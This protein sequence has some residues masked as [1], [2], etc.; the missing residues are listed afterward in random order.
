[1]QAAAVMGQLRNALR[2]Y[3]A[4]GH[5]PAAV[6][7][8]T[9]RL[10]VELDPGVFA[11][12]AIVT[13]DLRT[14]TAEV[15]LAGHPPPV[16]AR[17]SRAPSTRWRH[18]SG[19]RSA[20]CAG[21]EYR[22]SR[23]DLD[24]RRRPGPLHRRA[25]RGLG[26]QLRRR[27]RHGAGDPGRRPRPTTSRTLA[28][29]LI[30]AAVDTGHLSDDVALLVVR[31]DGL[32]A[33]AR[34]EH[35]RTSIDR[36]DPRAARSARDFIAAPRRRAGAHR[37]ARDRGPAGVRGGHQRAAAHRRQRR[38][39]AVAVPGPGPRRGV[40]RDLRGPRSR[41]APGCSTSPAAACR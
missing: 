22:T 6:M 18:R 19:H 11:T 14:A 41:R 24:R 20:S 26:P 38:P 8:R 40:R 30:A 12:C 35:D 33:E 23:V 37:P 15:V 34:P 25:G 36:L 13:V 3:A 7:S 2:A 28:D 9:N 27:A 4:E 10:M 1:M 32:P 17:R 31:H 16:R 5:E 39:R 29:R 21:E